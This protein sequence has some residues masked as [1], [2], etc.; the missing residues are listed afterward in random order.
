MQTVGFDVSMWVHQF[1][2]C[3]STQ[4]SNS[5]ESADTR[6]RLHMCG[7]EGYGES[8]YIMLSIAVVLKLL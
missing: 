7:Q 5:G 8:L 4:F 6:G 1:N 2:K 3:G